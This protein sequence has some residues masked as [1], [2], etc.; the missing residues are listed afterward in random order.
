MTKLVKQQ[1]RLQHHKLHRDRPEVGSSMK[2][3]EGLDTSSTAMVR[4]FLCSTDR[5]LT[6]G[7]PTRAL[8]KPCMS[9]R[10]NTCNRFNNAS[11]FVCLVDLFETLVVAGTK[12][13]ATRHRQAD[14]QMDTHTDKTKG[15]QTGR[16]RP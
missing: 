6:P 12:T 16:K 1:N 5:P 9:T 7:I 15:I 4:R 2:T 8:R 14:C 3:M 11:T 13:Q 10:S